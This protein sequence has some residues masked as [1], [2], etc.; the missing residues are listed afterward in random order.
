[1]T[2]KEYHLATKQEIK[3]AWKSKS[4]LAALFGVVAAVSAYTG[5]QI[6]VGTLVEIIMIAA[7]TIGL[8][9]GQGKPIKWGKTVKE[10]LKE[11]EAEMKEKEGK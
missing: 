11:G 3:S 9:D 6:D 7:A 4:I 8:R 2:E 1:M 5:G 10:A